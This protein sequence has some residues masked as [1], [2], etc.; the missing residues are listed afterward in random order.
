MLRNSPSM[1]K[2]SLFYQRAQRD[3][4]YNHIIIIIDTH[5]HIIL[6]KDRYQFWQ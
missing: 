2:V 4:L 6:F 1:T 5:L 3:V